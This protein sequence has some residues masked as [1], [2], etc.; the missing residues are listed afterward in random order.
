MN[1]GRNELYLELFPD[2]KTTIDETFAL[3]DN[4][5]HWT[6]IQSGQMNYHPSQIEFDKLFDSLRSFFSSSLR[7]KRLR[8]EC[9]KDPN[10]SLMA[11][12]FMLDTV[13]RNLISNAVKFSREGGIVT[14]SCS[15][16]VKGVQFSVKDD[17]VGMSTE[18]INELLTQSVVGT[19][20]G[21]SNEQG[22]GLGILLCREF[23]GFHGSK[24]Q[25]SSDPGKG[26]E[27]F[28]ELSFE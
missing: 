3:L 21:T 14:L 2:L 27:F 7:T 4:L 15:K 16:T 20:N 1:K 11:D 8:F 17:G 5:L 9:R 26:S 6:R 18:R 25:I 22:T 10:L 24:L 19:T 28:F 13:L 23:I 12:A